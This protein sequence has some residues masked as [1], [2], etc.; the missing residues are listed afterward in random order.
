MAILL[1]WQHRAEGYI[2]RWLENEAQRARAAAGGTHTCCEPRTGREG[3]DVRGVAEGPRAR[4]GVRAVNRTFPCGETRWEPRA[5]EA[6]TERSDSPG[7]QMAGRPGLPVR[8]P[9]GDLQNAAVQVLA[10]IS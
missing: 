1:S 3:K 10:Q 8:P 5:Q 6:Q 9:G 2:W 4:R 7:L